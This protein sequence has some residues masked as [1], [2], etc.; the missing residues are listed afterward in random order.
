MAP[1][2]QFVTTRDD[3]QRCAGVMLELRPH[4][5]A[6]GFVEQTTLQLL[7]GYQLVSLEN[8]GQVLAL[9]GFRIYHML[10]SGG[11]TL[12]IDDL[13]TAASARSQAYG[14]RLI[15][16]VEEYARA[17]GCVRLTLDSGV[18]NSRAHKFY[19]R[20]GLKISAFHFGKS[21]D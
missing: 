6:E 14:S 20:E 17:E 4:L 9:A 1:T 16:W 2:I 15:Q 18:D 10:V 3:L 8:D 19:S 13:V 21:L 11:K 5:T 12:Y 7:E